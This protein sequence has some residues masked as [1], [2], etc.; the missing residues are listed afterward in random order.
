MNMKLLLG[1]MAAL[2]VVIGG[3]IFL[4]R[5]PTPL[6][7]SAK[8]EPEPVTTP[9]AISQPIAPPREI[10]RAPVATQTPPPTTA[11]AV[12][13][14]ASV[15]GVQITEKDLGPGVETRQAKI[16]KAI[17]QELIIQAASERGVNLTAE[18][19]KFLAE[20]PEAVVNTA[21]FDGGKAPEA[22][23]RMQAQIAFQVREA[24][25]QFLLSTLV[26]SSGEAAPQAL[27]AQVQR[28]REFVNELR[29]A[30]KIETGSSPP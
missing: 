7:P 13:V 23:A 22:E 26:Q 9:A 17:D 5:E 28:S 2:V 29:A 24:T 19:Q 18:Q 1:I 15:N 20:M 8:T 25:A 14:L 30:A 10:P 21:A 6:P 16:D 4:T 27:S 12:P 3:M 11:P